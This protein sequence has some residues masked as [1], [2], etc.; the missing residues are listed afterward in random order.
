M[1]CPSRS[2]AGRTTSPR[3][4]PGAESLRRGPGETPRAPPVRRSARPGS[5][6][7][8]V[9]ASRSATRPAV[10]PRSATR[11]E[12]ARPRPRLVRPRPPPRAAEPHRAIASCK[13][14]PIMDLAGKLGDAAAVDASLSDLARGVIG[15]EILRIAAQI[16]ALKAQGAPAQI[17]NL[18]VGDFDPAQFPAPAALLDGVR[19]AL[20]A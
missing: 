6:A 20:A 10:Q 5:I 14:P 9:V 13:I 11:T 17:C 1:A 3:L 2:P 19:A 16:R 7:K 8:A 18:T 12:S 15:S 4:S